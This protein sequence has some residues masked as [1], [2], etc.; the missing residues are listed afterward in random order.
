MVA[1]KLCRKPPQQAKVPSGMG[2]LFS[3]RRKLLLNARAARKKKSFFVWYISIW[4][5][6]SRNSGGAFCVSMH[7]VRKRYL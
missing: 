2:D 3:H 5:T 1:A 4:N 7:N 6:W